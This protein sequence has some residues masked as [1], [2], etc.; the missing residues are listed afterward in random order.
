MS[1]YNI[2]HECQHTR[3][4]FQYF[5]QHTETFWK[6]YS[7]PVVYHLLEIDSDPDRHAL[8]ADP[9]PDPQHWF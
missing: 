7:I 3:D 5:L 2:S 6:K 9:D 1:V 8:D 4:K